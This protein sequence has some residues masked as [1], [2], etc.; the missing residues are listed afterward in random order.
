MTPV[1]KLE[2]VSWY[3]SQEAFNR[4]RLHYVGRWTDQDENW[5]LE[6]QR[7][8]LHPDGIDQKQ[9]QPLSANSWSNCSRGGTK[10]LDAAYEPWAHRFLQRFE[11]SVA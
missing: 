6:R 11:S 7:Q 8:I 3:P 2:K 9:G 4:K 1:A 5:L 10:K